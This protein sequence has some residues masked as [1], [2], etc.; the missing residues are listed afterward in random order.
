MSNDD[1]L[2]A[3]LVPKLTNQVENA[4]TDGLCY[5]L[6][7]SEAARN[8]FN[9]LLQQGGYAGSPIVSVETQV[10][11]E[12]GSRPD[13]AGYDEDDVKRL[14][15][16]AKFWAS[17]GETQAGEYLEQL[18]E[19]GPAIL[20]FIAPQARIETLWADIVHRIDEAGRSRLEALETSD[21]LRSA[22]VAGEEKR[23]MLVSWRGLLARLSASSDDDNV[24]G[25]IRQLQGLADEQDVDAFLP[26]HWEDVSPNIGRRIQNWN[27]LA[28]DVV[29]R[30]KTEKWLHTEGLR[31]TPQIYG[32]GRY[33]RFS[34]VEC[35]FWIGVNNDRWAIDE[36]TPLW[37]EVVGEIPKSMETIRKALRIRDYDQWIPIHLKKGVESHVVLEDVACQLKRIGEV[38]AADMPDD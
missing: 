9:L 18:D 27:R 14:L 11:Y 37:L 16:E 10:A 20:L 2:L 33:F 26:I 6:Q 35:D 12:D 13:M 31:V 4:A 23:L 19:P 32:Y 5:I 1:T 38:V 28:Y 24:E 25:D 30:G 15:V 29:E 21:V 8:A 36:D 7:K 17:L 22:K 34:G 3:Y